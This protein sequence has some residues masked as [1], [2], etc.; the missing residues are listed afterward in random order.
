[1]CQIGTLYIYPG[2]YIYIPGVL[3]IHIPVVLHI[4]TWGAVY[5]YIPGVLHKHIPVMIHIYTY[6]FTWGTIPWRIIVIVAVERVVPII[7]LN[8]RLGS[9]TGT[10]R[11]EEEQ[12]PGHIPHCAP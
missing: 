7:P 1:M 5:I 3:Y 6:I 9:D 12:Y 4:S 11:E 8:G 2:C 10:K